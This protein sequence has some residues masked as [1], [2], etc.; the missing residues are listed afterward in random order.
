[1][2][3]AGE[4]T[5]AAAS[6]RSRLIPDGDVIGREPGGDQL[7]CVDRRHDRV[8]VAVKDDE[9][10]VTCSGGTPPRSHGGEG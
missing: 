4:T 9:R 1:M 8:L 3:G 10:H 2:L 5:A 7:V 6:R